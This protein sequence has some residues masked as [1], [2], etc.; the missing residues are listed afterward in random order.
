MI[1]PVY[2]V[3]LLKLDWN[4]PISVRAD[5]QQGCLQTNILFVLLRMGHVDQ[6]KANGANGV[7]GPRSFVWLK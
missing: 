4:G 5:P 1:A 3:G 2:G 6:L 7:K